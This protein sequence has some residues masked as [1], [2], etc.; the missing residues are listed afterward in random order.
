MMI[1][2]ISNS[3]VSLRFINRN[4]VDSP[5]GGTWIRCRCE[6]KLALPTAYLLEVGKIRRCIY[7]MK[8]GKGD[9]K[10]ERTGKKKKKRGSGLN[11]IEYLQ[12]PATY[13]SHMLKQNFPGKLL[14]IIIDTQ[15][16]GKE[17]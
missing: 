3:K 12:V 6:R 15:G 10:K 16:P 11:K 5:Q 1:H 2:I 4:V 7:I 13:V 9:R 8:G 14:S 17:E